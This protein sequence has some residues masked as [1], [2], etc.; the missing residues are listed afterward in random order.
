M[1][2]QFV[3]ESEDMWQEHLQLYLAEAT[4]RNYT[5]QQQP[6]REFCFLMKRAP[7]PDPHTL[8]KKKK[9]GLHGEN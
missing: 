5:S 8:K 6:Y 9:K 2:K 7:R 1:G 4:H 3:R